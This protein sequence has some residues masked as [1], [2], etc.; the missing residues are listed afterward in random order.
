VCEFA[1]VLGEEAGDVA[2]RELP[3]D[4]CGWLALEEEIEGLPHDPLKVIVAEHERLTEPLGHG[5][6]VRRLTPTFAH[7]D[8]EFPGCQVADPDICHRPEISSWLPQADPR[9]VQRVGCGFLSTTVTV[10]LIYWQRG[11]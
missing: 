5:H 8:L 6:P 1:W 7:L 4:R 9:L 2:E 10:K 3:Q 11:V